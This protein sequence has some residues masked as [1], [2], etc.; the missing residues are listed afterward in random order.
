MTAAA[1]LLS[2][3]VTIKP[4]SQKR[5]LTD[6][7]LPSPGP[8][9]PWSTGSSRWCHVP[10]C[11]WK[12]K[13]RKDHS[14]VTKSKLHHL[15]QMYLHNAFSYSNSE[16]PAAVKAVLINQ[17]KPQLTLSLIRAALIQHTAA[18]IKYQVKYVN[19]TSQTHSQAYTYQL[20]QRGS[21]ARVTASHP[22]H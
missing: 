5:E 6:V 22:L 8:P 12:A 17:I 9:P 11:V 21:C 13:N 14:A 2:F 10:V 20:C 15:K 7:P 3:W 18:I 4:G 1:A 19:G 16:P